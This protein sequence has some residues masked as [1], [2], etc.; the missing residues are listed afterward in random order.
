MLK[1]VYIRMTII[2]KKTFTYRM[3]TV[4]SSWVF[5]GEGKR[6]DGHLTGLRHY[7]I[8]IDFLCLLLEA[9]ENLVQE[10]RAKIGE[11]PNTPENYNCCQ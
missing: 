5:K 9:L 11:R 10:N 7:P 2:R 6:K 8:H 3:K 1:D 4:A